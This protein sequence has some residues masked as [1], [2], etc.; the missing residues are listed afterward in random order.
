MQS[1]FIN[2]TKLT[3]TR[4]IPSTTASFNPQGTQRDRVYYQNPSTL[5]GYRTLF[6]P[7][8]VCVCKLSVIFVSEIVIKFVTIFLESNYIK[9]HSVLGKQGELNRKEMFK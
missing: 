6:L 2:S 7:S 5:L 1:S 9:I 8:R 4:D 3:K